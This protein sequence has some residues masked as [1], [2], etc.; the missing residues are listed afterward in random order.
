MDMFVIHGGHRLQG[1]VGVGGSKNS[2][3]PIMAASLMIDGELRL[4]G[5]P[6]LVDIATMKRL[7]TS[8]GVIVEDGVPTEMSFRRNGLNRAV[9]PYDLVRRMRASVCVLGPL[10]ARHGAACVSLP[11][12]CNIGHR[13][14]DLHLRGLAALGADVQLSGGYIHVQ[15]RRLKGAT[16]DLAGPHGTTVTGTCNL[17]MAA[18]LA[19]GT[20]VIQSAAREPEVVELSDVL[21]KA[22]ARISG[23]GTS[24]I[25]IDGV[26]ELTDASHT[27]SPD[28]IDATTLAAAA[29]ITHGD[30][31]IQNAPIRHM[32]SVLDVI[33]DVGAEIRCEGQDLI[34]RMEREIQ[35][36]EFDAVPY[37]GVPTDVQAQ[38]SAVLSV[39]HGVSTVRDTVFP[40]RFLHAA[41]LNRMGASIHVDMGAAV[42]HGVSE[43]SGSPVM[44]SDLRA[45]AA[46]VIA[47]LAAQGRTE[48]RRVYHLDRGYEHFEQRLNG[49]G[50]SI[51]RLDDGTGTSHLKGPHTG[52]QIDRPAFA[53]RSP[54]QQKPQTGHTPEALD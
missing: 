13:P 50:A 20:T 29:V 31:R 45:S 30:V 35:A 33:A 44:A 19:Q 49:L 32:Q 54:T 51:E 34:V 40:E 7:L 9:A 14:I 2:A 17:M 48:I 28:R 5:V 21:N 18:A 26:D 39:A 53:A 23:A 16:I 36:C 42:I 43:L 11:G 6:D 24:Q 47:A 15:A 27:I 4:T 12:G 46:L 41:E 1:S 8:M 25:V 22:G 10:V 37:P 52:R 3:L 38:L